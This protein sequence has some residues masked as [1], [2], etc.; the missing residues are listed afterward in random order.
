M[1][2]NEGRQSVQAG[3]QIELRSLSWY[4]VSCTGTVSNSVV[5]LVYRLLAEHGELVY[6]CIDLRR[7]Y[8]EPLL[9]QMVGSCQFIDM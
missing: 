1:R 8:G 5:A 9:K 6:V 4:L 7:L 3:L 2:L